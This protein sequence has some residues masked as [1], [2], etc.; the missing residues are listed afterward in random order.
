MTLCLSARIKYKTI[1]LG[2]ILTSLQF[3]MLCF[4][5]LFVC[6]PVFPPFNHGVVSLFSTH[7]F[8]RPFAIFCLSFACALRLKCGCME[9]HINILNCH[10]ILKCTNRIISYIFFSE[11]ETVI[12]E[13]RW[14]NIILLFERNFRGF[15]RYR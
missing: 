2:F 6:L 5:N 9:L 12:I 13:Y 1:C 4:V 10:P 11:I 14:F 15:R 3:S 7:E 8:E